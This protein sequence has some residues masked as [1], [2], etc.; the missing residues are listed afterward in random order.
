MVNC[1]CLILHCHKKTSNHRPNTK[2]AL[3]F[4]LYCRCCCSSSY[5]LHFFSCVFSSFLNF[6]LF[7][8]LQILSFSIYSLLWT[9]SSHTHSNTLC[10]VSSRHENCMKNS[11]KIYIKRNQNQNNHHAI[12]TLHSLVPHQHCKMREH[13]L[14]T[15]INN[16]KCIYPKWKVS[17]IKKKKITSGYACYNL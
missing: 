2:S 1:Y 6:L 5:L 7:F 9:F 8:F 3:L 12:Y 10:P 13:K 14:G 4:C 11:I 16:N 15:N 17:R